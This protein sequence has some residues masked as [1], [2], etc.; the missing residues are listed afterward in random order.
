MEVLELSNEGLVA[1]NR[2]GSAG[3]NET[4]FLEPLRTIAE[5]GQTPAELKLELFNGAWGGS[6]DPVYSEFS[7]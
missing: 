5:S 4:G 6:V 7:Y 2:L 1:R 3:D